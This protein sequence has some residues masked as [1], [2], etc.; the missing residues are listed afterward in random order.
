MKALFR[1]AQA[2]L[3]QQDFVEAELD[4]RAALLVRPH[5]ALLLI[6]SAPSQALMALYL[7]SS[8]QR[9]SIRGGSLAAVWT[10]L[11]SLTICQ[12]LKQ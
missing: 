10:A 4:I 12:P 3:A 9:R 11:T 5:L 7:A 2:H 1:R 6:T 8:F